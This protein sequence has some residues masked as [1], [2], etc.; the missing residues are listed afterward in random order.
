MTWIDPPEA[1][2][3]LTPAEKYVNRWLCNAWLRI[4]RRTEREPHMLRVWAFI[5][6]RFHVPKPGTPGDAL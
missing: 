4:A 5:P 6:G 3:E 1:P 2:R